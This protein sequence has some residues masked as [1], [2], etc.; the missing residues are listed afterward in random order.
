METISPIAKAVPAGMGQGHERGTKGYRKFDRWFATHGL[1]VSVT[2]DLAARA[3]KQFG[4][5]G[6]ANHFFE[7]CLDEQDR[8]WL[9]LHS[10]SRGVGNTLAQRHIARAKGLARAVQEPGEIERSKRSLVSCVVVVRSS[11][12]T[13]ITT[14]RV[15]R[16]TT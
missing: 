6:S 9:F 16:R 4:S 10:G 12:S 15:A 11:A 14:T 2:G 3:Q 5:L 13:A 1:P 7:V 8:V